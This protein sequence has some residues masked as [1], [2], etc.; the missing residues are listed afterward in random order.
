MCCGLW[1]VLRTLK[2]TA[3]IIRVSGPGQIYWIRV[4][5]LA[6]QN[7]DKAAKLNISARPRASSGTA[8]CMKGRRSS[9]IWCMISRRTMPSVGSTE[10]V[11]QP[12]LSKE[13][14]IRLCGNSSRRNNRCAGQNRVTISCFRTACELSM[15]PCVTHSSNGIPV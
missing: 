3:P 9:L 15:A 1:S 7:E 4:N 6:H 14:S 10:C 8:S 11:S 13:P 12:A 5:R 2:A